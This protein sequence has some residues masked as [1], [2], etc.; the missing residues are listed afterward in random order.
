MKKSFQQWCIEENKEYLLEEWYM[1]I[2]QI[3]PDCISYGTNKKYWWKC[4]K[5]HLWKSSV[6]NRRKGAGCPICSGYFPLKG[7]TDFE[8]LYPELAKEWNYEKN[9]CNPNEYTGR[10]GFKVWWKCPNGHSYK[11]SIANRTKA[12]SK[13]TACPYCSNQKVLIGFNDFATFHPELLDEWNYEK[14]APLLPTDF[15]KTSGKEV[16]WK[17]KNGHEW[18][19]AINNRVAGN[20]CFY[21]NPIATSY[22]EQ[23]VYYCIK[24][25]FVEAEN[26]CRIE[27]FEFDIYIKEL[28]LAI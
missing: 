28:N 12:N 27:N 17:C 25:L 5:N 21:C 26:R 18:K 8:T 20:G 15:T 22:S 24:K 10:S 6:S 11:A 2:N 9:T 13:G 1:P 19:A 4:E 7:K 16:W 23:Y 3:K 14:N